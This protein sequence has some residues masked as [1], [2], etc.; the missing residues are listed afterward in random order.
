MNTH[1]PL[2]RRR[3]GSPPRG[4]TLVEVMSAVAVLGIVAAMAVPSF[5]PD[6]ATQLDAFAQITASELMA[7]RDLAVTNN[8]KYRLT[9]ERTENRYRLEHSGTNPALNAL[10]PTIFP[11]RA[12]TTTRHYTDLDDLPRLGIGAHLSAVELGST[13]A[14]AT[15]VLEFGPLGATT[16]SVGTAVWLTAGSGPSQRYVAVR[17]DPATGIATVDPITATAPSTAG[18]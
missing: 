9:F 5:E 14:A 1:R 16:Q 8:S 15:T 17:V 3:T 10:P 7:A 4:I 11:N 13:P 2:I 18:Q 12:D 6:V